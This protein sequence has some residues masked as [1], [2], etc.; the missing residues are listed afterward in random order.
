MASSFVGIPPSSSTVNVSII[1]V[2]TISNVPVDALY[3]PPIPGLKYLAPA[4]SFCFLIEHASGKKVL[5]DLGIRKDW[6]N[7]SPR[8]V[9]RFKKVG[10]RPQVKKNVSEV[11]D[12][13]GTG[14]DRI[15][16]VIWRLVLGFLPK[17]I[18]YF[19]ENEWLTT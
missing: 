7:L 14:K 9:E 2:C 6:E 15:N 8:I 13:G 1:D 3:T 17:I 10:H 12:E 4:P 5:Y 16:A 11:L 18:C 19:L